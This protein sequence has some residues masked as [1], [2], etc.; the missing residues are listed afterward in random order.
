MEL[1]ISISR[2]AIARRIWLIEYTAMFDH[3]YVIRME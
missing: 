1:K 2:S 3:L